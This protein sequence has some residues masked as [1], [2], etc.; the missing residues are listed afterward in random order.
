[1]LC[2]H[3]FNC[4]IYSRSV[5]GWRWSWSRMPLRDPT[6]TSLCALS[7]IPTKCRYIYEMTS[8]SSRSACGAY[9][10]K[11]HCFPFQQAQEM[12]QE[13]LRERDHGGFS[14]RNDFG[15]RMGGGM[16]VSLRVCVC[17]SENSWIS[18]LWTE[19][20]FRKNLFSPLRS[21]YHDTQSEWS[22]GAMERWSRKSKMMPE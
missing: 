15:S 12:V 20:K 16:D 19:T 6:S 14:E 2:G 17:V 18:C 8:P 4:V 1:M 9:V 22:L 11:P 5:Q 13:I 3:M 7:A 10:L 21:Q